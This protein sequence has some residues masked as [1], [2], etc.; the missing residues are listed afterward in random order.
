MSRQSR[1]VGW[2]AGL[3]VAAAVAALLAL[4]PRTGCACTPALLAGPPP[5]SVG[6]SLRE[7]AG[8]Q[9]RYRDAHGYYAAAAGGLL[10]AGATLPPGSRLTALEASRDKYRLVLV[11]GAPDTLRCALWGERAGTNSTPPFRIDCRGPAD[12]SGI[13]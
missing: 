1:E 8:A 3:A 9:E 5:A 10:Q 13:R 6:R 11:V 12:R 4:V 7:L 2:A